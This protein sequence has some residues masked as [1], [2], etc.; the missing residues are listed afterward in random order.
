[1]VNDFLFY[2]S[3]NF[4]LLIFWELKRC[5]HQNFWQA[6]TLFNIFANVDVFNLKKGQSTDSFHYL[7]IPKSPSCV[8]TS[9]EPNVLQSTLLLR[10]CRYQQPFGGRD[11]TL[12]VLMAYWSPQPSWWRPE[13]VKEQLT[14]RYQGATSP[15][16][17]E[18]SNCLE[19]TLAEPTCL[20][21]AAIHQETIFLIAIILLRFILKWYKEALCCMLEP[22]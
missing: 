8:W 10:V 5:Q 18:V 1:M 6:I 22:E 16:I 13:T 9:H 17:I 2:L 3:F 21:T 20:K 15:V 11:H 14:C 4:P 7:Q 19:P 12:P